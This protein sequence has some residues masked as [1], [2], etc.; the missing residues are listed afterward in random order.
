MKGALSDKPNYQFDA[1]GRLVKAAEDETDE[2]TFLRESIVLY[3]EGFSPNHPA[4]IAASNDPEADIP[5][6][7]LSVQGRKAPVASQPH[8]NSSEELQAN[9]SNDPNFARPTTQEE[10]EENDME[11]AEE[12]G[13]TGSRKSG[14]RHR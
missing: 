14:R 9:D 13:K 4:D 11:E 5:P 10:I 8:P 1:E 12:N 2:T 7:A 6:E 3:T